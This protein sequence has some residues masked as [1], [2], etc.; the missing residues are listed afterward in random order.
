MFLAGI[1]HEPN[2][3]R[4]I[5]LSRASREKQPII[6]LFITMLTKWPD[7]G[8]RRNNQILIDRLFQPFG[9]GRESLLG[10]LV[11]LIEFR[12]RFHRLI[13]LGKALKNI[14]S[15]FTQNT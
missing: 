11:D 3:G 8:S 14:L 12:P 5:L 9:F 4:F 6:A 2:N 15:F 1:S 10:I 13:R 7:S